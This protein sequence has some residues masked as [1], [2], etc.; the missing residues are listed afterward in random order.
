MQYNNKQL[1]SKETTVGIDR[2]IHYKPV[3][4]FKHPD[5]T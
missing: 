3:V 4:V 2:F 1:Q 5:H